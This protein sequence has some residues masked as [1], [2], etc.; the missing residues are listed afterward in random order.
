MLNVETYNLMME[1]MGAFFGAMGKVQAD[2]KSP[3][4]ER[5][6]ILQLRG[7][8]AESPSWYMIQAAEFEPEPLTVE[9]LRVRDTY[10]APRLVQALLD[11]LASEK[12]L[13]QRGTE[14]YL[15]D[16]GR[17]ILKQIQSRPVQLMQGL[18]PIPDADLIRLE[19][20]LRRLIDASL[21]QTTEPG[22]W[23]LVHSR[24]RAPSEE[25]TAL[26]KIFHYFS[27]FNA[28]RDD[29][30]M[31]A[32]QPQEPRGHVWEAFAFVADGNTDSALS[33]FDQLAYRGYTAEEYAQ[34]LADVTRRGWLERMDSTNRF[35]MTNEGR[36]VR[37]QV[38][39]LTD[40]YFYTSW[41][42]LSDTEVEE[43]H[44]LLRQLR[45]GLQK[46]S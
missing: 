4:P 31:A 42:V 2:S 17:A 20:L 46:L 32:F 7:G 15:T 9:N 5:P 30:H 14:Y 43:V 21:Q 29:A 6:P 41:L 37:E 3:P 19:S 11:L 26:E 45:D 22:V 27:D 28:F 16:A 35:S 12:W 8:Y 1:T 24:N 13:A 25:A 39:K 18:E 44:S 38:E 34:A 23:C 10:A 33:L 40:T 36:Q